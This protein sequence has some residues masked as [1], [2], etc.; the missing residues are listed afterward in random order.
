MHLLKTEIQLLLKDLHVSGRDWRLFKIFKLHCLDGHEQC[1][2]GRFYEL[3]KRLVIIAVQ[4]VARCALY[5]LDVQLRVLGIVVRAFEMDRLRRQW[6]QHVEV[7]ADLQFEF[8]VHSGGPWMRI[9]AEPK[10]CGSGSDPSTIFIGVFGRSQVPDRLREDQIK[11]DH[12][13]V[14]TKPNR[15]FGWQATLRHVDLVRAALNDGQDAR[16]AEDEDTDPE[17]E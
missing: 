10:R 15:L 2:K 4:G 11:T 6:T 1:E 9:R 7:P 13:I 12:E 5:E 8:L 14:V 17:H 3:G 16:D